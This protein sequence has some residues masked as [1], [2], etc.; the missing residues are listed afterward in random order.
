MTNLTRLR[1]FDNAIFVLLNLLKKENL[2]VRNKQT[3]KLFDKLIKIAEY[4]KDKVTMLFIYSF[5]FII[6]KG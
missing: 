4:I 3:N 5:I 6:K 2:L 1:P